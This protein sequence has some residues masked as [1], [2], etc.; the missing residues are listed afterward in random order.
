MKIAFAVLLLCGL[1]GAQ[2]GEKP[3]QIGVWAGGGTS[4]PGGTKDT[5]G[6]NARVRLGKVP[7]RDLG[8]GFLRGNF[9]WSADLMPLY[10]VS[11]PVKNS[12]GAA[13]NPVNLTLNRTAAQ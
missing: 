10:Y 2:M 7:T 5:R 8:R 11:P 1:A 12:Y 6:V 4:V 9:E 3:W 13:F